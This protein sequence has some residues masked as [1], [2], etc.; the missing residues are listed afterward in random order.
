MAD[1]VIGKVHFTED[2]ELVY[3]TTS[4]ELLGRGLGR[5]ASEG[6]VLGFEL[7]IFQYEATSRKHVQTEPHRFRAFSKFPE[8][9]VWAGEW[10]F[11]AFQQPPRV[12]GRFH[13]SRSVPTLSQK[14]LEDGE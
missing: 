11:L 9:S 12:V 4:G 1:A 14:P 7:D 2:G 13:A 5:W 3:L 6:P 8:R 10:Q